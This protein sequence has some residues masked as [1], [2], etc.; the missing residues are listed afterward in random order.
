MR[1]E[2]E[3]VCRHSDFLNKI[4]VCSLSLLLDSVLFLIHR[5]AVGVLAYEILTGHSPFSAKTDRDTAR[6]IVQAE[7]TFPEYLSE[8]AREFIAAA[9]QRDPE[10]RP[11]VK[12]LLSFRLIDVSG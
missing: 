12:Q 10:N 6:R 9:L 3:G 1:V 8:D 7:Y 2:P 11:A 5:W 4:F